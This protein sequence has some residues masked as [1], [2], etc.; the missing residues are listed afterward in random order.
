MYETANNDNSE[1]RR[2]CRFNLPPAPAPPV[3]QPDEQQ[4]EQQQRTAT[5]KEAVGND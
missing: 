3:E 1:A 2:V 4:E 5:S